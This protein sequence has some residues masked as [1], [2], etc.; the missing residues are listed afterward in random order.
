MMV[1]PLFHPLTS[2][3]IFILVSFNFLGTTIS[4]KLKC[5][6]TIIQK[7]LKLMIQFYTA[8]IKSVLASSPSGLSPLPHMSEPNSSTK[9]GQWS[10]L[11]ALLFCRFKTLTTAGL[12]GEGP[13][14]ILLLILVNKR[15]FG[16]HPR[17]L[18]WGSSN[19]LKKKKP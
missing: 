18:K 6:R 4:R 19:C 10:G 1:T 14:D 8:I 7:A 13:K 5:D 12:Q 17:I 15:V 3:T 11:L 2:V 16:Q 9:S